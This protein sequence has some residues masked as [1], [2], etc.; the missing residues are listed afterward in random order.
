MLWQLRPRVVSS[1]VPDQAL[2][3]LVGPEVGQARPA[4]A[5]VALQLGARIRIQRVLR[6]V[7]ESL[8]D[9]ATRRAHGRDL[10]LAWSPGLRVT[11]E[12]VHGA[13][14]VVTR[15]PRPA[16]VERASSTETPPRPHRRPEGAA[17]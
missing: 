1:R 8:D 14:T 6:V 3:P 15:P 5:D 7:E 9:V 16:C 17:A 10:P 13:C 4:A 2:A 12:E 11:V